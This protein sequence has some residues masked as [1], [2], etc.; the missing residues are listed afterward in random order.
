MIWWLVLGGLPVLPLV[1]STINLLTWRRGTVQKKTVSNQSLSVLIP[2]RNEAK[3]IVETIQ[4]VLNSAGPSVRL[5]EIL[6]YDDNSE[7]ATAALIL[8]NFGDEPRVRVLEGQPLP[9]GWIGKP[10]ACQRLL[11]EARGEV[12]LFMDA[13]V[14][15][16]PGGTERLLS[17]LVS[18]RP[19]K[20]VTAVPRQVVGGFF[21]RLVL[22][23]LILTYTS[24]LPLRLVEVGRR[25]S[26]V[27]ANG[28]LLLMRREVALSLGGFEAVRAEIVDD[29]AFCRHAKTSGYRVVF[30]DGFHS[31]TIRK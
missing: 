3:R 14:H 16:V 9:I 23:L 19:A 18:E 8:E 21:E 26:T 2:A 15:L 1:I 24:W 25:G 12:L 31:A 29:V 6:V 13:D 10:H 11:D 7:D 30:A 22:P 28:Q 4:S 17:F 5:E 20:V 27:A